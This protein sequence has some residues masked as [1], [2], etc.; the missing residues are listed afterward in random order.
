MTIVTILTDSGENDHYVASIK[1]KILSIY[2]DLTIIDISHCIEPANLAQGSFVLKSVFR[3]F[4]SG[5]V[6]LVGVGPMCRLDVA[7]IAI[8]LEDHFFVGNN[9]GILSLISD[10]APQHIVGINNANGLATSFPE[11]DILA[12]AVAKIA[13]EKTLKNIGNPITDYVQKISS[14]PKATKKQIVG[15]VIY[16]DRFGN[17]ITS[18]RK[19]IFLS[20]K[21]ERKFSIQFGSWSFRNISRVHQYYYEVPEGECFFLF[22]SLDLLEIGINN[23]IGDQLFGM[24]Y[25]SSVIISFLDENGI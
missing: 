1:A 4:P 16:I 6:H 12:P 2:S 21:G 10:Q 15:Q 18:I 20:L 8:Q 11:K 22:N 5:T 7:Y 17:L 19:E 24:N 13:M 14:S 9:N 23:G 25:D 3:D